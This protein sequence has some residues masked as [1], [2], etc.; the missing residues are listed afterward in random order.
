MKLTNHVAIVTGA[1]RGIGKAIALELARCGCHVAG[2]SR[3]DSSANAIAGEITALGVRYQ[4]YGVDVS[5]SEAVVAATEAIIKEFGT[6]DILV[7]NAGITRDTLLMRMS[8][9]DWDAVLQTNLTGSFYWI[10]AVTRIMMKARR[11]RIVNISS[12]IGQHGNAG[13]ANYAAAK[14]GMIGLTQ[15]VAK[16][17]AARGITCN[18]VCPGFIQTDMTAELSDELKE[19]LLQQIPLRR[20][21][22]PEDVA[23]LTAFLCS[24]EAGYITGQALTVD[25]GLFI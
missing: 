4:G 17:F 14:A 6:V 21:G 24:E 18:A 11:G 5:S 1:S 12:V 7:N 16:E 13:Q 3:T 2:I 10:K 20:L 19:K 8:D 22:Q 9:A 15:S 25:G 23:H